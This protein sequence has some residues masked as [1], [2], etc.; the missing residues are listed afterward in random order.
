MKQN[1]RLIFIAV[2]LMLSI[3]NYFRISGSENIRAIQFL[4]IFVI[5]MLS[6]IL[7]R[8][9]IARVKNKNS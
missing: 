5:G 2:L 3:G 4:S 8:E 6:G 1:N 7:L 9:I